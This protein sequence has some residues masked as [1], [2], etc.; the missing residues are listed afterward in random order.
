MINDH[1]GVRKKARKCGKCGT[2]QDSA[3]WKFRT[4][5]SDGNIYFEFEDKFRAFSGVH[6]I[7]TIYIFEDREFKSS[8]LQTV[9]KSKLK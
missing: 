1:Y 9:C 4:Q 2:K 5:K 8:T 3:A 6:F 7:H